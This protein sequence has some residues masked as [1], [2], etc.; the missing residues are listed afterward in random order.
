MTFCLFT[1]IVRHDGVY[2]KSG[3]PVIVAL[4]KRLQMEVAYMYFRSGIQIHIPVYSAQAEHILVFQ[5][6]TVRPAVYFH[7][8]RIVSRFQIFG[9]IKFRIIVGTLAISHLFTV[10][11]NVKATIYS[12][13]MEEYLFAVPVG[14]HCKISAIRTHRVR[15]FFIGIS[16][17]RHYHCRIVLER[18]SDIGVNRCSV[19][20]H[21]HI[22]RNGNFFP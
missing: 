6:A 5:I 11:P 13:E 1:I 9:N 20:L 14:R 2:F 18:I 10:Y 7:C 17:L 21:L 22:G 4:E 8:N 3:C 12:V 19:S 15:F 16:F